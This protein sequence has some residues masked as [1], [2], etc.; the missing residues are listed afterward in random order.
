MHNKFYVSTVRRSFEDNFSSKLGEVTRLAAKD[1]LVWWTLKSAS[2][3][4]RDTSLKTHHIYLTSKHIVRTVEDDKVWSEWNELVVKLIHK[5]S[6]LFESTSHCSASLKNLF[7]EIP[8]AYSLRSRLLDIENEVGEEPDLVL[9]SRSVLCMLRFLPILEEKASSLDFFVDEDSGR[10]GVSLAEALSV[11]SKKTLDL[12]FS[13][14]GEISYSFMEGGEGYS[15][16]SGTS[17]LT[18]YLVNSYKF[19]KIINIFDY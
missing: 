14:N 13:E 1:P 5:Y 9:N 17:Y 10:L 8:K 12:Q 7:S 19:R 4:G 15:R 11:N 6:V 18:D 3:L 16:I 2:R